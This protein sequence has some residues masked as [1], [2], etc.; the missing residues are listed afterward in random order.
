MRFWYHINGANVATLRVMTLISL[1]DN[2]QSIWSKSGP[3]GDA[4]LRGIV[5]LD[6]GS[7]FQVR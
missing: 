3:Q 1:S 5:D 2:P 6:P 4:W 7:K